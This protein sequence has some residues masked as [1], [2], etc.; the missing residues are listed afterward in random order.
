[1]PNGEVFL[2][3]Q[4]NK[5]K[6]MGMLPGVLDIGI[7]FMGRIFYLDVKSESGELSSSQEKFCFY[8]RRRGSPCFPVWS[9]EDV[10][11]VLRKIGIPLKDNPDEKPVKARG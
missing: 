4:I 2:P 6:A 7:D 1:M 8:A 3:R 11:D 5:L 9:V 10:E